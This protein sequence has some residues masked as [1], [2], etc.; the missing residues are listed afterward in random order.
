D[1]LGR[2]APRQPG[3]LVAARARLAR[4]VRPAP[5]RPGRPRRAGGSGHGPSLVGGRDGVVRGDRGA[6]RAADLVVSGA[7]RTRTWNLRFWRPVLWPI[8]LLPHRRSILGRLES[9]YPRGCGGIGRRAG[10]RCRW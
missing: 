2:A 4:T 1:P 8:E 9:P 7:A 3:A 6:D 10:F 5:P